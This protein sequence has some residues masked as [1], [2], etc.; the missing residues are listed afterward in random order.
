MFITAY[1]GYLLLRKTVRVVRGTAWRDAI[2]GALGGITGGLAGLPGSIVTIWCGMRGWDRLRQRAI[3]Q[4]YILVMQIATLVALRFQRLQDEHRA[5]PR[6]VPFA[7]LGAMGGLALF[8]RMTHRAVPACGR[9]P[10]R[11]SHR[12]LARTF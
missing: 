1:A 2:A 9:P 12:L 6:F 11:A 7:L 10:A 8:H 5:R 4:P 3:Y